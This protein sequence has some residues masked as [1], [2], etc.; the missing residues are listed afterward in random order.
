MK[1]NLFQIIKKTH[2]KRLIWFSFAISYSVILTDEKYQR[3]IK[4]QLLNRNIMATQGNM[5]KYLE[6]L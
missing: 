1:K 2:L 4:N 6:S 5:W 3:S